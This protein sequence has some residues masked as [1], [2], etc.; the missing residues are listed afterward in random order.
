MRFI[1]PKGIK[2]ELME[3]NEIAHSQ[4][5]I[6]YIRPKFHRRVFA[7]VLDAILFALCFVG[8]FLGVRAIVTSDSYYQE[9]DAN[10]TSIKLGSSLYVKNSDGALVDTVSSLKNDTDLS[11]STRKKEAIKTIDSF[12]VYLGSEASEA[13]QEKV[14]KSYDEYRMSTTLVYD[15]VP[16]FIESNGAIVENIACSANDQTYF[17]KAYTPFIDTQCQGYLLTEVPGY[18]DMNKYM[19]RMVLFLEIPV[20]YALSGLLVYLLPACC[21]VRGHMSLG[22]ALYHIGMVDSRCLNVKW[23]R[24]FAR[25]AIFYFGELLLS[26]VTFGIPLIISFSLMAFSKN[27]QGFPDYMLGI[28]EVD[29]SRNKIYKSLEEITL[30]SLNKRKEPVDFRLPPIDD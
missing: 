19:S 27:K 3:E 30:E 23:G 6:T 25:F 15:D 29:T 24:F 26:L 17:E 21:F 8:L 16:Y 18:Y 12:I 10:M 5:E 22:K 9:V 2:C 4:I 13:S 7:N 14:Q 1:E 28:Q 20:A 11:S